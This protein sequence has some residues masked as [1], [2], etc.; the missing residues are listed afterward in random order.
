[1]KN[2]NW[3]IE[4]TVQQ[5][6]VL[7]RIIALFWFVK[8]VWSYKAWI[9]DRFYPVIPA[10][11][12]FEYIPSYFDTLLFVISLLLLL[13]IL[14]AKKN[15]GLLISFFV[16]ELFSCMLDT[17]RWQPWEYM[18][19]SFFMAFIINFHRPKN[20]IVLMHL[21]LVSMYF[22]SGLHKLNRGF[23][24]SVWM[25]TILEDF[26]GFSRE[27]VLKYKL[28]FVGLVIPFFE[29]LLAGLLVFSKNKK[30]VSYFLILIHLSI[31]MILGPLG[32][33]YNSI[34]WFWNLAIIFILLITYHKP[35]EINNIKPFLLNHFYWLIL[36]FLMPVLSFFGRWY[37]YFSFNLY[38]GKGK[39]MYICVS[40]KEKMQPQFGN[41]IN[42]NGSPSINLQNWA[43]KE[44]ELMPI[45]EMEIYLKIS[46]EIKKRYGKNNVKIIMYDSENQK[47]IKL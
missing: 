24:S 5:A 41:I 31:L 3:K 14:F 28:F 20:I 36:W 18:Y 6:N 21:L 13:I 11:D 40:S 27:T 22:F 23:L 29:I 26:M 12:F 10:F 19:L 37:Q 7:M 39:Q 32:L 4:S 33:G 38:S 15:R 43:M 47:I 2:T 8:K 35:F 42:Y 16:I 17:V 9:T 44:M 46:D 30:R 45:P 25:N 1:M 34:V